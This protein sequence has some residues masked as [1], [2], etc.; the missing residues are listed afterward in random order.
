[1]EVLKE[2]GQVVVRYNLIDLFVPQAI[3]TART[4]AVGW[5]ALPVRPM[6]K[7]GRR[8][9]VVTG[10]GGDT[11]AEQRW[12]D[13]GMTPV[14]IRWNAHYPPAKVAE[15]VA[16]REPSMLTDCNA[17]TVPRPVDPDFVRDYMKRLHATA[18]CH[19]VPYT[20]G[21][22]H[23]V[24]DPVLYRHLAEWSAR[25]VSY[26]PEEVAKLD[27]AEGW[28]TVPVCGWAQGFSDY[29][30]WFMTE[31]VKDVGWDGFYYDNQIF[32]PCENPAHTEH[33]FVDQQGKRIP[34]TPIRR[35]R[36][37]YKRIYR[38][39]KAARPD[40]L[41]VGH[42][43]SAAYPFID[44]AIGGEALLKLAGE[45]DFYPAFVKPEHCKSLFFNGHP[46]GVPYLWLPEYRGEFYIGAQSAAA[47]RAMLSLL[48]LTDSSYWVAWS[49]LNVLQADARVRG[50]FRIWEAEWL[51]YWSQEAVT[52]D[53]DGV[54][55]SVYRKPDSAL[56]VVCNP[57]QTTHDRLTL[58]VDL[59]QVFAK[60][61][62][63]EIRAVD[64][65]FAEYSVVGFKPDE[66]QAKFRMQ[67]T[68]LEAAR[69][70]V[71]EKTMLDVKLAVGAQDLRLVRLEA[72]KP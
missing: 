67:T 13:T 2:N 35:Y 40:S 71:V 21:N 36:E 43:C 34:V 20:V 12:F 48:W 24:P 1:M 65:E 70:A 26:T 50:H 16:K 3:A 4:I 53:K 44:I 58:S 7:D 49:N 19:V 63:Q 38:E 68:P 41:I 72:V 25:P 57:G 33:Q 62:A 64:A 9:V 10:F 59:G 39:V 23:F 17:I 55:V 5:N 18:P 30:A 66:L 11:A 56:L 8:Y 27:D 6:P 46:L 31:A 28:H 32:V 42:G 52:A 54:Y 22:E 69:T 51:P 45:T 61:P 15:A 60:P 37:L 47:T 14:F 29:K